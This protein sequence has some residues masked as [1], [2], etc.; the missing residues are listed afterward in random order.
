MKLPGNNFERA[1]APTALDYSQ[2]FSVVSQSSFNT[3]QMRSNAWDNTFVKT[4]DRLSMIL[5][6]LKLQLVPGKSNSAIAAS[7]FLGGVLHGAFENL[8][9]T[10]APDVAEALY[11]TQN[12]RLKLYSVLPPPYGGYEET[13]D[14]RALGCGVMLFGQAARF[15]PDVLSILHN[16]REIRLGGNRDAIST[17]E[18]QICS[19]GNPPQH[20]S[21]DTDSI[22]QPVTPDYDYEFSTGHDLAIRFITPLVLENELQKTAKTADPPPGLLRIVRSLAK[23]VQ[24]LE[25][26][27]S[28]KLAIGTPEWIEAEERIRRIPCA[29]TELKRVQW[30]YGSRTKKHPILRSGLI[31]KIHYTGLIPASIMALVNWGCWFGVGQGASLGQGMYVIKN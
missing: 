8:V 3:W 28:E 24:T 12:N 23:R 9:R 18:I 13:A 6:S 17:R 25:P 4:Q 7:P 11:M 19:P 10:H 14:T 30:R 2:Y 29:A 21:D 15:L 5:I 16:W 22:I 20:W 27:L 26:N 31:G 1:L